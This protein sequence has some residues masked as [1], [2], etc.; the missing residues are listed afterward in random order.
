MA[1]PFDALRRDISDLGHILGDTLVEQEGTRPARPRGVDPR[2]R[3]AAPQAQPPRAVRVSDERHHPRARRAAAAERVA[4]AFTHYFQL[5]NLAEQHHRSRRRRDYAREQ[6]PQPGSLSFELRRLA[7]KRSRA[8]LDELLA[9]SVDRARVHR[10]SERGAAAH[11]ARQASPHRAAPHAPRSHRARPRRARAPR[12]GPPRGGDDALADRRDPQREAARRRRGEEHAL[13]P[14][15]GPLPARPALLRGL[16]ARGEGRLRRGR[17]RPLD[18]PALRLVGRR[19]HGRQPERH[20]GGRARHRVRA[21]RARHASLPRRARCARR[22]ALAE[23][24]A[25]DG[26]RGA[27]RLARSADTLAM[28]AVAAQL[29]ATTKGEPYRKK[30]RFAHARLEATRQ[31]VDGRA[32]RRRDTGSISPP[33]PTPTPVRVPRRPRS[34]G[35]LA[36]REPRRARGSPPRARP[37]APGRDV[38]LPSR[39]ARRPRPRRVGA[40]GGAHLAL[41]RGRRAARRRRPSS[42]R[43]PASARRPAPTRPAC[44]RWRPSRTSVPSPRTAA[45]SRSSSAWRTATRTCSRRSSSRASP[46]SI[47]PTDGV[48]DVSVVPALRDARRSRA[49]PRRGRARREAALRTA[50]TSIS[51][52]ACRR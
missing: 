10:A 32:P 20:A 5:V 51:A 48:A 36:R 39:E 15:G 18:A 24:R 28:P 42:A 47:A 2:A 43:S 8:Q 17:P 50:A 26:E 1:D 27:H 34:H 7:E 14:R 29:E 44:A 4:R 30:L 40:R 13:L 31:A 23:H 45:P 49:L 9:R 12:R 21:G 22:G 3:Q 41:G 6:T 16:R 19:R 38:R 11:R 25:R 37:R 46:G 33:T 52:A 35:A